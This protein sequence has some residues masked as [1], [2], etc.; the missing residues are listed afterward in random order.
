METYTFLNTKDFNENGV[1]HWRPRIRL[2][3]GSG[4][5]EPATAALD[6]NDI[7]DVAEIGHGKARK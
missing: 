7:L 1:T 6:D 5:R 4:P 2:R 3:G